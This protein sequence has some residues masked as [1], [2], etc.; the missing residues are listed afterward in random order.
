[1]TDFCM[2]PYKVYLFCGHQKSKMATT[3]FRGGKKEFYS[4]F[5]LISQIGASKQ[6][7]NYDPLYIIILQCITSFTFS[8]D[9]QFKMAVIT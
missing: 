9:Q 7:I 3:T 5:F 1:M 2:A 8:I 6:Y 4:S